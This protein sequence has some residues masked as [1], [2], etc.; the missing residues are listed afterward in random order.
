EWISKITISTW[1]NGSDGTEEVE[2]ILVD[3]VSPPE[4]TSFF[5][6]VAAGVISPGGSFLQTLLSFTNP[7]GME[8]NVQLT[9]FD[10]EGEPS[11]FL[12]DGTPDE[13]I[14]FILPSR[15]SKSILINGTDDPA[16]SG[17]ARIESS[18]PLA[19]SASF[20]VVD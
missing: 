7:S 15:A 9:F 18:V 13:E 11:D 1:E 3:F 8:G 17:Y 4:F 10:G 14:D 19:S 5:P 2:G 20:R 12:L 16:V 6:Q